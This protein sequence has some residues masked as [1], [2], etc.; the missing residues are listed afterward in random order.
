MSIIISRA[1]KETVPVLAESQG[2][3]SLSLTPSDLSCVHDARDIENSHTTVQT[4]RQ[5]YQITTTLLLLYTR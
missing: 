3:S 1:E 5:R 2:L 4:H